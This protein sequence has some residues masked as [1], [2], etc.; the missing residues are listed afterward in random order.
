MNLIGHPIIS[1]LNNLPQD[2]YNKIVKNQR[3]RILKGTREKALKPT[4][5]SSLGYRQIFQQKS[6]RVIYSK[7]WKKI[8]HQEYSIGNV[9]FPPRNKG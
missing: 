6:Y 8:A 7:Y 2:N 5:E 3:Q 1:I 9:I 4:M